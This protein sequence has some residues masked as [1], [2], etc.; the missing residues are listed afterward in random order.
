MEFTILGDLLS[1][2]P[3]HAFLVG[4][5]L[6][7][8]VVALGIWVMEFSGHTI[9]RRGFVKNGLR[10]NART[11]AVIAV[12]AAIYIALRPLQVQFVPGI[13]G[14]NPSLSLGPVL[15]ILFGIPGAIGVTF[16]MPIGDA[17][18]GALT[19]GSVAGCLGH[20][21][22]TWVPYKMVRHLP[23][24]NVSTWV[25]LYVGILIGGLLHMITVCGWLDFTNVLPPAVI[26]SAVTAAIALNHIIIPAVVVP[27]LLT[28][29]FPLVRKSG[30]WHR[31]LEGTADRGDRQSMRDSV[32]TPVTDD[33]AG[34]V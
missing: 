27:I 2:G 33:R 29:L 4:L 30:M 22:W 34:T 17:I 15:S 24:N 11:I 3:L 16:S 8:L 28:A 32:A 21:F 6:V 19:V 23:L 31:D 13:G 5:S 9:T 14:F 26:W 1:E 18:S 12:C 25:R 20:T 10:W 7:L